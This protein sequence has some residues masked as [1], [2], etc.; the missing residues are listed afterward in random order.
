MSTLKDSIE[1]TYNSQTEKLTAKR[2]AAKT[3]LDKKRD[4]KTI[5]AFEIA[6]YE[7]KREVMLDKEV[8]KI[9]T[10]KPLLEKSCSDVHHKFLRYMSFFHPTIAGKIYYINHPHRSSIIGH[11]T[12]GRRID[13]YNQVEFD[14]LKIIGLDQKNV[15]LIHAVGINNAGLKHMAKQGMGIIWSPFSNFLLYGQTADITA[16]HKAGVMLA[17]GSD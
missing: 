2:D 6:E 14:L 12:E 16:A 8:L 3:Q 5:A 7:L 11:L 13:P 15:N 9:I 10:D 1:K 17:L 4:A